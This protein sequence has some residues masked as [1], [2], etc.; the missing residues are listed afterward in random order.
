MDFHVF[1]LLVW[2]VTTAVVLTDDKAKLAMN[3]IG[4]ERE[5]D[6]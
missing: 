6:I 2:Q 1:S 4:N 3:I 5:G